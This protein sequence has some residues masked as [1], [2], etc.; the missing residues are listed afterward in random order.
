MTA[1]VQEP[2][3]TGLPR[4]TDVPT[5]GKALGLGRNSAYAAAQRGE[6]PTVRIGG[7]LVVPLDAL[8]AMLQARV[9]KL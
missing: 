9:K 5:A 6:I 7:Q 3:L 1:N 2:S 4:C 8:H